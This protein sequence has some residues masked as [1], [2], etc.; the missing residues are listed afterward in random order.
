MKTRIGAVVTA[1][2]CVALAAC[3]W[4]LAGTSIP[5]EMAGG[6]V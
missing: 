6:A 3:G 5:S 1:G 2:I 4:W